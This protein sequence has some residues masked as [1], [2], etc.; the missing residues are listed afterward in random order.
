M[1]VLPSLVILFRKALLWMVTL[2]FILGV[3]VL[4]GNNAWGITLDCSGLYWWKTLWIYRIR[5]CIP[6]HTKAATLSL[7]ICQE[8]WALHG[9]LF[10]VYLQHKKKHLKHPISTLSN[11]LAL[12][13]WSLYEKRFSCSLSLTTNLHCCYKWWYNVIDLRFI[14]AWG[15]EVCFLVCSMRL[16]IVFSDM[17]YNASSMNGTPPN[18][19]SSVHY[20][21]W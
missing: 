20:D 7:P 18:I 11:F 5:G 4:L 12:I 21:L 2:H 17:V 9:D 3:T 8:N 14:W 1:L 10:T 13:K 15:N 16:N 19:N 6:T